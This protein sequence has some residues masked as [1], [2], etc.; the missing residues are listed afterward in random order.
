MLNNSTAVKLKTEWKDMQKWENTT[1]HLAEKELIIL[2]MTTNQWE[3]TSNPTDKWAE[4]TENLYKNLN[5]L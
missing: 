2:N 4:N 3:M 1:T 5:D